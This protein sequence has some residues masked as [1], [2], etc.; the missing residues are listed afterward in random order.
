MS[1]TAILAP[2][3]QQDQDLPSTEPTL[4]LDPDAVFGGGQ[5]ERGGVEADGGVVAFGAVD[6]PQG[7]VVEDVP[8]AAGALAAVCAVGSDPGVSAAGHP[9]KRSTHRV[10]NVPFV[11]TCG[12]DRLAVVL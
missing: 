12:E 3:K 2:A 8:A 1:Q 5:A 4:W 10:L 6:V 9:D 7:G 11:T